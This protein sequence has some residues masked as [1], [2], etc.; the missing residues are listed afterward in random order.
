MT[1]TITVG[2]RSYTLSDFKGFKAL[3]IGEVISRITQQVPEVIG[4]MSD[5]TREY[6][7]KNAVKVTRQ[8][9]MLPEFKPMFRQMN[10]T[11]ADWEACGG[12]VELPQSPDPQYVFASVFPHV[13]QHARE[14]VVQLLALIAASN[15]ELAQWDQ[16]E[17][18]TENVSQ[19][20]KS[21][22]YQGDLSELLDLLQAGLEQARDELGKL[23]Q[24]VDLI[25]A[26]TGRQQPSQNGS[27]ASTATEE[28]DEAESSEPSPETAT[29][30][31]S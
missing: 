23:R 24:V 20:G 13:F 11:D 8:M 3:Q 16:E 9:S 26:L 25:G 5:Y 29:E 4:M 30:K 1:K 18:L 21:L 10:M 2:E 12:Y 15:S 22:L 31:Q 7:A 17:T 27:T 28:A 6:E 14:E 19:L